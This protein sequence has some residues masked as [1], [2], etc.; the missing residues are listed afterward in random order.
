MYNDSVFVKRCTLTIKFWRKNI[1]KFAVI[2]LVV[3]ML[4]ATLPFTVFADTVY[5][6]EVKTAE[7]FA[8]MTDG[9]YWLTADI[10]LSK[11]EW[12]TVL[13]FSGTLNGNGHTVTVP[14][15]TTMF[16]MFSGTVKNLNLKG[17]MTLDSSDVSLSTLPGID[18]SGGGVGALA[19]YA[20]GA[21]VENVYS[22]ANLTYA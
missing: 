3:L 5:W 11:T 2:A 12:T 17:D 8:K 13:K 1:K 15:N 20:F 18:V 9:N 21:T 22:N 19:N 14:A 7:D 6:T 4:V 16:D 10:D